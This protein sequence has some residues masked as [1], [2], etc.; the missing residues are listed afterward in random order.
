MDSGSPREYGVITVR[1]ILSFA[2]PSPSVVAAGAAGMGK[3]VTWATRLRATLPAFGHIAGGEIVILDPSVLEMID[4]NLTL[5]G[6]VRQLSAFGVSV[7]AIAGVSDQVARAAADAANLP[8]IELPADTDLGSLE[9][10]AARTIAER[11][12]E[13]QQKGQENG[14]QLMDMAI[15]G[16][17]I[18]L[19]A[20]EVGTL[21]G[22]AVLME[23]NDGQV[24]AYYPD[25]DDVVEDRQAQSNLQASQSAVNSWLRSVASSSAAEPPVHGWT[26]SAG[27][28][29]LV[30]PVTGRSGLLGSVSILIPSQDERPEDTILLSRAAAASAVTM[31]QEQATHAARREVEL[32]VLDELLDGALRS[33]I[34]LAQQAELL[35]H[36]LDQTFVALVARPDTQQGGAARSREVRAQA[37]EAGV[38]SFV[39]LLDQPDVLWRVRNTTA[40]V[41]IP[42]PV[43]ES[44]SDVPAK[45]QA[46]LTSALTN[47]QITEAI[48]IGIGRYAN[49][50]QGIRRSHQDARQALTLGRRLHGGSHITDYDDLG[51]YRLI[52]AAEDLPELRVFH[53]ESLGSLMEYDRV[54]NSNLVQTLEAYFAANCSPKEASALLQVHRNTV[55]YRL[56]RIANITGQNLDDPDVRLRFHLALYVRTAFGA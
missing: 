41:V 10:T 8:L 29:R 3:E 2:L 35:G 17:P 55:L 18:S 49:G 5:S 50:M 42:G 33:E 24:L 27:W 30:A 31:A 21:A 46:A 1:D 28:T 22:R 34:A 23:S 16:D 52:L 43:I 7:I 13:L 11:R 6:A 39:S 45:L 4:E 47:H 15:A 20:E 51:I 48:S 19:L 36:N 44:A 32:N 25:G 26:D 37:L 40:E 38:R 12:R 56:E 54:H 53:D 9:R 14:R